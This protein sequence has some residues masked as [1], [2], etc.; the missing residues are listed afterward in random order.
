[1]RT[2]HQM[3][4]RFMA[5]APAIVRKKV[6]DIVENP[7]DTPLDFDIIF[8]PDAGADE[9]V[10]LDFGRFG[11]SGCHFYLPDGQARAYRERNRRR[12]IAWADLPAATQSAIVKY[13]EWTP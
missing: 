7:R 10:G 2:F 6:I 13:L 3:P 5:D 8:R 11:W 12:R 9:V 4:R 1:M